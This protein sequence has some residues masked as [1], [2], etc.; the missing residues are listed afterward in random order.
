MFYVLAAPRPCLNQ[1]LSVSVARGKLA[2]F[3]IGSIKGRKLEPEADS[4]RLR[5]RYGEVVNMA[6]FVDGGKAG[7]FDA[8]RPKINRVMIMTLSEVSKIARRACI[9]RFRACDTR[10]NRECHH[11]QK[12]DGLQ[13]LFRAWPEHFP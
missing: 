1:Y 3:F 11:Q 5:R 12:H 13:F 4:S 10:V 2:C 7:D 9:A 6:R 8:A